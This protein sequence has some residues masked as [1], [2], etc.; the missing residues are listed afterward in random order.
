MKAPASYDV[1][2]NVEITPEVIEEL[3]EVMAGGSPYCVLELKPT[4]PT[5]EKIPSVT[6]AKVKKPSV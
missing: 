4:Q 3:L 2:L 1:S 6:Q 5:F